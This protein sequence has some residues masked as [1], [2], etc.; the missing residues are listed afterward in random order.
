MIFLYF[1]N[2]SSSSNISNKKKTQISYYNIIILLSLGFLV[3]VI[4]RNPKKEGKWKCF[5]LKHMITTAAQT[6]S[7]FSLSHSLS[8][9][10]HERK[11]I[12]A[13]ATNTDKI[14]D[15]LW[16]TKRRRRRIHLSESFS[17]SNLSFFVVVVFVAVDFVFELPRGRKIQFVAK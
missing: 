8:L 16:E 17:F 7:P 13:I 2:S 9:S 12:I 11:K 1:K 6:K 10:L 3:V 5:F 14:V 4:A 15:K